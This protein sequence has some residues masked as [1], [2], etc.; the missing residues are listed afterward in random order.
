MELMG[1]KVQQT[2][3]GGDITFHGPGQLVGYPIVNLENYQLGVRRYVDLLED[4]LI[5]ACS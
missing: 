4:A 2:D 3:R 5:E 1:A